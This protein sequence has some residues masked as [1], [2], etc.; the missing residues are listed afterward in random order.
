[1]S[2]LVVFASRPVEQFL[3]ML[4]SQPVV[5]CFAVRWAFAYA[6]RYCLTWSLFGAVMAERWRG[7]QEMSNVMALGWAIYYIYVVGWELW[8]EAIIWC[9]AKAVGIG[10]IVKE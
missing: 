3:S 8:A 10:N 6:V 9:R 5:A 4:K 1:M 2:R 7:R